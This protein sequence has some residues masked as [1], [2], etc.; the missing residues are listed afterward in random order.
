MKFHEVGWRFIGIFAT[1]YL[2]AVVTPIFLYFIYLKI[3][4]EGQMKIKT[5]VK[6]ILTTDLLL[7]HLI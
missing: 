5:T 3:L 2:V 1:K 6:Y 4:I 7:I